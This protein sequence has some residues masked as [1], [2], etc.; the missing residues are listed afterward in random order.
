MSQSTADIRIVPLPGSQDVLTEICRQRSPRD[1]GQGHRGRSRRLD[2]RC[3]PISRTRRGVARSSATARIP[4]R[5]ILTGLGPIA[6]KQ[7]RVQDR[8]PPG[9]RESFSPTV[10]PPYLR[11]TKNIDEADPLALS[12]R[13]QHRRLPR[14]TPRTLRRR[15]Q[16]AL[17]EHRHPAQGGLGGR[18]QGL[19]Q[20]IP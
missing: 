5:T 20:A 11:R 7:P 12:Q 13:H 4:R 17:G 18:I 15:S 16:G 3:T 19:E 1:V 9:Q 8:R 14:G 2:R 10:L 6:V